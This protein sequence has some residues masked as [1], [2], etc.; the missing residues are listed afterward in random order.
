MPHLVEP[1]LMRR[2]EHMELCFSTSE[3][4]RGA[5]VGKGDG[6]AFVLHL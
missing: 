3:A 4:I 5:T 6:V 2:Q 1:A